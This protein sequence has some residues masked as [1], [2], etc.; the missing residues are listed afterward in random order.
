[1]SSCIVSAAKIEHG[2]LYL[3]SLYCSQVNIWNLHWFHHLHLQK[4]QTQNHS[5]SQILH[6]K[7]SLLFISN[8]LTPQL[9]LLFRMNRLRYATNWSSCITV[10]IEMVKSM[11]FQTRSVTFITEHR[12]KLMLLSAHI[13]ADY[14]MKAHRNWQQ[15]FFPVNSY[16]FVLFSCWYFSDSWQ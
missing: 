6:Y 13:I 11:Y 10:I 5:M 2:I 1:M 3:L 15:L 4:N 12:T 8:L 7:N 14:R 9:G 16:F